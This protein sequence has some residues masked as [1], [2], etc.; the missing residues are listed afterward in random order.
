M[1]T[2]LRHRAVSGRAHQDRAVHLGG[3]GDHVLDVVSVA[4]AVN[5]GVVTDRGFVFDVRGR[6]RDTTS[7]FFR[8]GVDRGVILEL[9]TEA[10]GTDLGQCGGQRGLAVIDVTD[11]ADVDVRLGA[12]ELTLCHCS[13]P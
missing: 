10:L 1:L 5:V 8:R 11:G 13:I 9:A 12:L 4:R 2:G 3:T 6:D 7:L